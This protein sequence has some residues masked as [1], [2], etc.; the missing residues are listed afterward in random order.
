MTAPLWCLSRSRNRNW[1]QSRRSVTRPAP[2]ADLR[3]PDTDE[4]TRPLPLYP[5]GARRRYAR[6]GVI[7]V[8]G[9][10]A[11]A[12]ARL[13]VFVG[14]WVLEASF[15]GDQAAQPGPAADGPTVRSRFKW[16]LDR[17]FLLQRTE[18]AIPGP[19]D[20]LTIVTVDRETGAYKQHYY[21]SRGVVRLYSMSL[22]D[23][24][25]DADA[26][27]ARLHAAGFPAAFHRHVQQRRQRHQRRMG[28]RRPRLRLG[29]RLRPYLSQGRLR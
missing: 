17:Q 1:S 23:G 9:N 8:A 18:V 29:A 22:F 7:V 11:D 26:G 28:E 21:D 10:R 27:V 12:L 6:A 15:P 19:P 16:T 14:E 25:L 24:V 4:F 13:E 2:H 20:S 3:W 5:R